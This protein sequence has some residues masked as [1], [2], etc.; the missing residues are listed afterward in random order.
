MS[1]LCNKLEFLP[2]SSSEFSLLSN[3]PGIEVY[4]SCLAVYLLFILDSLC[5]FLRSLISFFSWANFFLAE[6]ATK[7]ISLLNMLE[8]DV[9]KAYM[10]VRW[11]Y[12][13]MVYDKINFIV[14]SCSSV[15]RAS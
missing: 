1:S 7:S 2:S 5:S 4:L 13:K 6:Q 12:F 3:I 11:L 10:K 15:V 14:F 8:V 9:A